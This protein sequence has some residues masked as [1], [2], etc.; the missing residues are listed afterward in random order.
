MRAGTI[1]IRVNPG[2]R[3]IIRA[4]AERS[5][6]SM[7]AWLRMVALKASANNVDCNETRSSNV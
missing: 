7:S 6:L 5:G 4:A 1:D 3:D 2:E